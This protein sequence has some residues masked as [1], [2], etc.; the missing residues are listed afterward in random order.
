MN[1]FNLSVKY[2]FNRQ[3]IDFSDSS[4]VLFEQEV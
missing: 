2:S 1:E 4:I 3:Y